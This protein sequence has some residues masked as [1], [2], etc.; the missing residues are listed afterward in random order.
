MKTISS[1]AKDKGGVTL[2]LFYCFF[3]ASESIIHFM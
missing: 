2:L 3:N 1:I